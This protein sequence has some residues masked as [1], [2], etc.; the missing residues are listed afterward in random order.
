MTAPSSIPT[1][2]RSYRPFVTVSTAVL[3]TPPCAAVIVTVVVVE[4]LLVLTENV[5]V[6][7]PAVI[8]TLVGTGAA[9]V[10][11]LERLTEVSTDREAV[12]VTV[13]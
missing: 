3:V 5:A 9:D 2:L 1:V 7:E 10:L 12:N 11:L 4:T 6:V 8:V 13:P